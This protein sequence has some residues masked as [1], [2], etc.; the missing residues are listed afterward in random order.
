MPLVPVTN[1]PKG[2][3]VPTGEIIEAQPQQQQQEPQST[4]I[5]GTPPAG[6]PPL[7]T[8]PGDIGASSQFNPSQETTREFIE[9]DL[10]SNIAKNIGLAGK[11]GVGAVLTFP[12]G[13]KGNVASAALFGG[14]DA[15]EET[16]KSLSVGEPPKEALQRGAVAG[17][18]SAGTE[19]AL[20]GL[21]GIAKRAF[22]SDA[23]L[24]A[25]KKL[26]KSRLASEATESLGKAKKAF[27]EKYLNFQKSVSGKTGA[28]RS[29]LGLGVGDVSEQV[30]KLDGEINDLTLSVN[31]QMSES[32]GKVKKF[33]GSQYD[34]ILDGA[35][36]DI[37]VNIDVELNEI[38]NALNIKSLNGSAKKKLSTLVDALKGRNADPKI[39]S[40]LEG[41]VAKKPEDA[42]NIVLRDA[43]WLKQALSSVGDSLVRDPVSFGL[44]QAVRNTARGLGKN[45]DSQVGGK[46]S[47]VSGQWRDMKG[48]EEAVD[49]SVG[50]L[51]TLFGKTTRKG[52]QR[53]QNKIGRAAREGTEITDDMLREQDDTIEALFAQADLLERNDFPDAALALRENLTELST[54]MIKKENVQGAKKIILRL[55]RDT[56]DENATTLMNTISNIER[57]SGKSLEQII[58]DLTSPV[59]DDILK[60]QRRINSLGKAKAKGKNLA[61]DKIR[62]INKEIETLQESV[63]PKQT[64]L[65]RELMVAGALATPLIT[66]GVLDPKVASLIPSAIILRK[67][68]P[69]LS[70]Q[71]GRMIESNIAKK[72]LSEKARRS[73]SRVVSHLINQQVSEIQNN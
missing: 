5:I 9:Q 48:V 67:T 71:L 10:P 73:A 18:V 53:V 4:P 54:A 8:L 61:P 27:A 55:A 6:A 45:I 14:V 47:V 32:V 51:K 20:G 59:K 42:V 17:S 25:G 63:L 60:A 64:G 16:V 31:K 56:G 34:E 58:G 15:L 19:L 70:L 69:R 7:G 29:K 2:K 44:G 68:Y 11:V 30:T 36:G 65:F 52:K 21:F 33:I 23:V 22:K 66:M 3:L 35:D 24:G 40:T 12:T 46:Y 38:A 50:R 39:I 1:K 26:A 28:I 41:L 72:A 62:A 37:P 43:H 57:E 49:S 13:F